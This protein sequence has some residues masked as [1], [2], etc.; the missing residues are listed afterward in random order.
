MKFALLILS[1]FFITSCSNKDENLVD[2]ESFLNQGER[3]YLNERD[4]FLA[5]EI[6][7]KKRISIKKFYKY[8]DW[9]QKNH[10]SRNE[11]YPSKVKLDKSN[12][13]V[14]GK[15]QKIT[16]IGNKIITI[17]NKSN[18]KI[19]D[20]N[21]KVLNK[22]KLYKR[23]IYK[24]YTILFNIATLENSLIV[25]D[26]LGNIHGLSI[27]NLQVLWKKELG[28]PFKSNI[29]FYKDDLYLINT[30][31][32]IF[33][34]N[35]KTGKL[36]WSYE[37]ASKKLKN[38]FSYRLAIF[39]DNLIFTND[40]SEI[41]CLDLKNNNIK[42]SL[43]F[44]TQNFKK[45]P[46]IF[47]ASPIVID[48]TGTVFV[49][50]NYGNTYS[51]NV[52]SGTVNWIKPFFSRNRVQLNNDNLLFVTEDRFVIIRKKDGTLLFN[53]KITNQIDKKKFILHDILIGGRHVYLFSS[54]GYVF[55]VDQNN[56][57]K[58]NQIRIPKNYKNYI[59]Y[60][61]NILIKTDRSLYRY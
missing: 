41:Y 6:N 59:L 30:N 14:N 22:I 44:E 48:Q 38:E 15:F 4:N 3:V 21:F 24:N 26:N 33:S 53:K 11:I 19:Y 35:S 46:L 56:L 27:K 39:D 17:D 12:L 36:N 1:F 8:K 28:V 43:I 50:T 29:K 23:K 20:L 52:N 55:K 57:N 58:I 2:I 13:K 5:K 42:W 16:K 34:I 49:S 32:K 10:N 9:S 7:K 61:Q 31:S 25:A 51:I 37:T 60:N 18:I 54:Q 40:S 47:E 45:S